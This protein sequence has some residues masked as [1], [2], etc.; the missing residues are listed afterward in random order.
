MSVL[1]FSARLL[2]PLVVVGAAA[3]SCREPVCAPRN[4]IVGNRSSLGAVVF[5]LI[6][7]LAWAQS[8]RV[9]SS[10]LCYVVLMTLLAGLTLSSCSATAT[11]WRTVAMTGPALTLSFLVYTL[12]KPQSAE[13]LLLVPVFGSLLLDVVASMQDLPSAPTA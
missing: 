3:S 5:L 2:L 9:L 6:L 12:A 13:Q 10:D 11:P 1:G 8:Q 7:G 4:R